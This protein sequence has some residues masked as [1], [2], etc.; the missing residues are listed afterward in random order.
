MLS[1]CMITKNEEKTL[2]TLFKTIV[3]HVDEVCITDTGSTDK[4]KEVCEK[5]CGDKLKWSTFEWCHDF[6]AAR[7]FNFEQAS[8]DWLLWAD[9]DDKIE[10]A[11]NL[12]DLMK[13]CD[14]QKVNAVMFP[15]HY[16]VDKFGNTTVLQS[17]ERLIKNNDTYRWIGKLHEALLPVGADAK[18]IRMGNVHWVHLASPE[19]A[20]D[21]KQRNLEILERAAEEEIASDKVD[22]RTIFNLGN[23]YFTVDN[24]QKALACYQKYIPISGWAE[25]IYLARHRSAMSLIALG[26]YD[27]AKE[28]SLLAIKEK[29]S[30]PDAYIDLGKASYEEGEYKDALFYFKDALKKEYPENLPVVNPLEYST[31]LFWLIG[32]TLVN[33]DNLKDAKPYF[34]EYQKAM[35]NSDVKEIIDICNLA[36]EQ[37]DMVD[38]LIKVGKELD[39][40]EFYKLI[41][42]KY[43][44]YPELLKD[45]NKFSTKKDCTDKDIAIYCGKSVTRWDPTSEEKGGVG[46]SEEAIINISRLL[47]KKGWNIT[48]YGR[49][50]EAGEYDGVHYK[51]YTDFNPRDKFNI[52]I[53]WRMPSIFS[54]DFDVK[55]KYL[56]LHDTHPEDSVKQYIDKIDKV[57]VLSDY[58]RSL[59]PSIPDDKFILSGNG[60]NPKHFKSDVKKNPNYCI[61]TSAPD[62]GLE[63]LLK[64]WPEIKKKAPKAELHWFYGW[65]TFDKL[66]DGNQAKR[67]WKKYICGL[68]DQDG[69]YDEGRVDHLTIAKKYQEANLWTYP[70]EF[71]EIYCITADKAQAGGAYPVTTN[72]AALE[73]RVK[74]GKVYSINDIYTNKKVQKEYIKEVVNKLTNPLD[75]RSEMTTYALTECT[76]ARVADQWDIMFK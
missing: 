27:A 62:R 59:Y 38:A 76:W 64:M 6:S 71:T 39:T 57:I 66:H 48:V 33:L 47:A 50:I 53:S 49:P 75:D 4:T 28:Q 67:D 23:A 7:K 9:A 30:Y 14:E 60:I 21:S 17:R 54:I 8:G 65:Q 63:C 19:R 13:K 46:G 74:H 5:Y 70:T 36:I 24:Y 37:A 11:E 1:L 45:K 18:A 2:P 42:K 25:E 52:L 41:P 12:A 10:G 55:T 51:H 32:H 44:E 40:K 72:V 56:W 15:Y 35:P 73:E 31:N 3:N 58:H 29:P 22:P 34:V 68:L 20:E 43:L 16:S 26:E 69:V 61:F